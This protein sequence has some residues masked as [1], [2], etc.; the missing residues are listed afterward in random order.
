MMLQ[1]PRQRCRAQHH[2]AKSCVGMDD[3]LVEAAHTRMELGRTRFRNEEV[4]RGQVAVCGTQ[5]DFFSSRNE[6]PDTRATKGVTQW[7]ARRPSNRGES[8]D[9]HPHAIDSALSIPAMQ[10]ERSAH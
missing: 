5:A 6:V 9:E 4:A 3:V 2:A 7:E 8:D 10:P 1:R